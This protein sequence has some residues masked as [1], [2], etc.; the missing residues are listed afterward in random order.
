MEKNFAGSDISAA[1]FDICLLNYDQVLRERFEN[2]SKG[3]GH[4][5]RWLKKSGSQGM[6][7]ALEP[8][9]RY[10][11]LLAERLYKANFRVVFVQPFQF[12]RYAESVDIRGKSD[13]KDA[14]A[15]ALYAKERGD[16]LR[17]WKPKSEIERE[18]RDMQVLIR[19]LT[20]Q[21]ARLQSQLKCGLRSK[22]VKEKLENA[23]EH[24]QDELEEALDRAAELIQEDDQTGK[25]FE[26]LES[27]CGIGVKST[28]LLLT[29]VPFKKFKNSRAL[30]CFLGLSKR[31]HQSG[32]SIQGREG[33][34]KRGNGYV[35]AALFMP[36]RAARIH[37]PAI[38]EFA[39]RLE[40]KGKHD[41]TIQ[42]AVIRK[43][44]TMAW[45]LIHNDAE[46]DSEYVNPHSKAV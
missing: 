37:N 24:C 16:K 33:I 7:I 41:W 29:L 31:K 44:V 15:L 10:G 23:L 40:S 42:M 45:A 30:V 13:W 21:S 17:D 4:C 35:R 3:I 27:I 32:D 20:K 26:H 11:D 2:N 9:G 34:S 5:I 1:Y 39:K 25:E 38:A 8:T 12:R 28:V 43:L 19:G 46:W 18:L 36:A 22:W 14:Y 6:T